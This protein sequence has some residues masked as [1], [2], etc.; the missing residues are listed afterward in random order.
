M[1]RVRICLVGDYDHNVT[2]HQAIPKALALAAGDNQ[3]EAIWLDTER[4]RD[5]DLN[6]YA[7][8]W[9]VPASP[10]R[11]MEGALRSIRF[12]RE[13]GRPFLG[14]CGGCQH[15]IV[16]FAQNV[17]HLTEAGHTEYDPAS[18]EP[19]ISQLSCSLVEVEETLL[20]MPGSRLQQ[21][22][23]SDEIRETYHCSFGPN[24]AYTARLVNGGLKIAATGTDG[25][26]RALELPSHPFFFA[27]LFQPERSALKGTAHPLI[28]S[29]VRAASSSAVAAGR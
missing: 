29:F 23:G 20:L 21:I 8:F 6:A 12:A 2:A 4:A 3:V 9:C 11:S 1:A 13:S 18:A 25:E 19:V 26:V 17:L 14:T 15:A 24:P 27:T 7:G 5:A 22:Y 16:E 10:Y 28:H